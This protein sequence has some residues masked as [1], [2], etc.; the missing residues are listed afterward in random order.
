M[1]TL[2]DMVLNQAR[3][4]LPQTFIGFDE[5]KVEEYINKMTNLELIELI[6]RAMENNNG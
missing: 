6:S 5:E 1:T 2:S 4:E 3:A